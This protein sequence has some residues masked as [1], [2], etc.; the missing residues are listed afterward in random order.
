V[1]GAVL[2]VLVIS[3]VLVTNEYYTMMLR[4]GGSESWTDAT[5]R[6]NAYIGNA[7]SKSVVCMDW[8]ILDSLR[9]LSRGALP[10][11]LADDRIS[12]PELTAEDREIVA[13]ILSD[14][15][16]LYI[17][18]T[19]EAQVFPANERFLKLAAESG[20]RRESMAVIADSFGRPTFEVYR[21]AASH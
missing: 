18:H 10:L 1:T 2:A 17:A 11:R 9:F 12:K 20:Y 6:L 15:G 7:P 8:G 3:G 4:N 14:T 21:L 5:F 16:N 19:R 13:K